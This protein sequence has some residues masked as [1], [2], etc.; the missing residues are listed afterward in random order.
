[1]SKTNMELIQFCRDKLGTP[2]VFGMKGQILTQELLAQL[3]RENPKVYTP[4]YIEKA[5]KYVGRRCTDCSGL[6]SWCTGI[7]RGSANYKETAREIRPATALDET[8]A[9]WALWKP[10]HIG[11]YVGNGRCIEAKGI[12]YGTVETA[13]AST[14]WVSALKL[15]D[16]DYSYGAGAA[17][18]ANGD[19]ALPAAAPDHGAQLQPHPT[20]WVREG[21]GV[22]FYLDSERYVANDWY[23]DGGRWF[24]FD[25]SGYAVR[26]NWY[27]YKESWYYFG[28]DF[29]MVKGIQ[30]IKGKPYYFGEDGQL[31]KLGTRFMVQV[32]K[33]GVLHFPGE[34]DNGRTEKGPE[35]ESPAL[36]AFECGERP[37][38]PVST[39]VKDHHI[40]DA[41]ICLIKQFEGCR[42]EAYRCAAGVPTIG[43]G[44][45]SGV[46]MG[47]KIT[48][49]E[50]DRYLREDL[51]SFE[52]AVNCAL[53]R[54][55]SQ[56]QFDALVSFTYNLGAGALKGSTLLK[57]LNA[58]NIKGAAD[59][60][61]KWNKA[62]GKVLE[63]LTKRRMK[64][65]QLFL[66]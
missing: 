21:K 37:R 43:Y 50:A 7:L 3:A 62:A 60:F 30:I 51:K 4:Q 63:G 64:E 6:I 5:R 16:I 58:G 41:G 48:Q 66:S 32:D 46:A 10:G 9:G 11:V 47:T 14:P 8:M 20:G 38:M 28:S 15:K 45:T 25:G 12:N 33:N 24:W 36:A 23:E 42:L 34:T 56:N 29:A 44:H 53:T 59:E 2:Y 1:M 57:L 65:R 13:A 55:V 18:A 27:L 49:E 54:P 22:R 40:S 31:A 19:G 35:G 52:H 61:P 26:D 39:A 17:P